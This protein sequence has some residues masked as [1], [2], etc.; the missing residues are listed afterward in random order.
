MELLGEN[1]MNY[2]VRY[3]KETVINLIDK[4]PAWFR[5]LAWFAICLAIPGA[6]GLAL[7]I[8]F[9][10]VVFLIDTGFGWSLS[11]LAAIIC[12]IVFYLCYA[13]FTKET[14]HDI[15][16]LCFVGMIIWALV[17][18]FFLYVTWSTY[19]HQVPFG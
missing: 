8:I 5:P 3:K 2:K 16:I 10:G 4:L 13:C 11:L 17:T 7:Y 9:Q 14:N 12:F 15:R 19:L 6:I 18:T 1:L